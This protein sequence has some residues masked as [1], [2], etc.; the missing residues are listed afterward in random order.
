MLFR[1]Y[2]V[3]KLERTKIMNINLGNLK[4]GAWRDLTEKE[5]NG[6]VDM[7]EDSENTVVV[8][9]NPKSKTK[10]KS[11]T[12][13]KKP[14]FASKDDFAGEETET[15]SYA[16]RSFGGAGKKPYFAP[17]GE[18]QTEGG[19]KPHFAPRGERPKEEGEGKAFS[20]RSSG[21]GYNQNAQR[22]AA[23]KDA[24][25]KAG[26]P[27]PGGRAARGTKSSGSGATQRGG[28]KRR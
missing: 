13:G 12:A 16:K 24:K 6:L 21:R 19:R 10:R 22:S 4:Q 5:L 27:A 7:I 28:S 15:K 25:S 1:S 20:K 26:R 8:K 17:K 18:K 2:Q 3:T 23:I 11:S 9:D 14:R